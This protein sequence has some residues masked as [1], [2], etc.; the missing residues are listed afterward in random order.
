MLIDRLEAARVEQGERQFQKL[1]STPSR[2]H[3]RR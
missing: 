1:A 3:S 2:T